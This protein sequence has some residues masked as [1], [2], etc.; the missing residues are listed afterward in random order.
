MAKQLILNPVGI[1]EALPHLSES[2]ASHLFTDMILYALSDGN[3]PTEEN[4]SEHFAIIKESLHLG[5]SVDASEEPTNG[6]N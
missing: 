1:A 6:N 4:E 3:E 5:E 2:E